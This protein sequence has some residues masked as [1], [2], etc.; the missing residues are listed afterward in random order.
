MSEIAATDALAQAAL[1]RERQIT[2]R[3]L[4]D[5]AIG[6]IERLNPQI[7][8]VV[9]ACFERAQERAARPLPDGPF[10]GVPTLVKDLTAFEGTR[11]TFGSVCFSDYVAPYTHEV[12][13][14]LPFDALVA[15]LVEYV[16][17]TPIANVTGHPAMSVPLSWTRDGLP[18]GSHFTGRFGDEAMLFR[19]A[20]Q[21]EQARPWAERWPSAIEGFVLPPPN[22]PHRQ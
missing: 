3:E 22:P 6:R 13:R 9:T 11:L 12:V 20:A 18:V 21:L 2:A 8:A 1:V 19:L 5:A 10:A 16:A 4:V 14:R 7:N 15:L 17:Y